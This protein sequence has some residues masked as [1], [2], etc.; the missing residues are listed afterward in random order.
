MTF[1]PQTVLDFWYADAMRKQWFASTPQ[2]DAEI[3][4]RFE[5]IWEAAY[6]GELE[7]WL[8]Q[9]ESALALIIVLDQFPLN[10]FRGQAKSFATEAQAIAAANEAIAKN[11]HLSIPK[12]RVAFMYLPLMHSENLLDQDR[13]VQLFEAAGL[14]DNARFAH[15]HRAIIQ[16]FGRFPHRN[17]ILGRVSTPEEIAYLNSPQAFKG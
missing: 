4:D 2:L 6:V 5:A 12:E 7:T 11:Y 14:A 9:P 10:M 1:S 8:A 16:R 3:R 17:A 15:H 13:C